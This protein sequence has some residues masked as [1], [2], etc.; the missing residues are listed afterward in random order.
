MPA[1]PHLLVWAGVLADL[2][3]PSCKSLLI[4]ALEL[5]PNRLSLTIHSCQ[6]TCCPDCEQPARRVHSHYTRT[7]T[8]VPWAGVAARIFFRARRF[9]CDNPACERRT[10]T[11]QLPE[12]LARYARRTHRLAAA[13]QTLAF[14]LG[15]EPGARAARHLEMPASPDTLLRLIRK[16]PEITCP[17]P[18]V[19]GVDDWAFRKG[20]T[21]GTILIDVESGG[22]VDLLP[23]RSQETFTR[24]LQAH[25]GIEIITRD[26]ASAYAL[27]AADGAPQALQVA[28]RFHLLVNLRKTVERFLDRHQADLRKVRRSP[29]APPPEV[30]AGN[31]ANSEPSALALAAEVR[32]A[33]EQRRLER[34]QAVRA[35]KQQGLSRAAIARQLGMSVNTARRYMQADEFPVRAPNR[36]ST[37]ERFSQFLR[38]RWQQGCHSP[39]RLWR[40]SQHAGFRGS[41]SSIRRW[42]ARAHFDRRLP[43][44]PET[45]RRESPPPDSPPLSS[46]QAAWVLLKAD[47]DLKDWEKEWR[48]QLQ[49]QCAAV[50]SAYELAQH[51]LKMV[52]K[53]IPAD[54]E[55]WINQATACGLID[56]RNFALN[57]KRDF[58]AVQAA[59]TLP[60]SNGP[61]EGHVHRLK[62]IKRQMYGRAKFDLLRKRVLRA[63]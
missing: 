39:T 24:W 27:A 41:L 48:T 38:D 6:E 3:F 59:L 28:D 57:L 14:A 22:P 40:D 25:P 61:T 37:A 19:L 15:G 7:V 8:D 32:Q 55:T 12:L 47:S 9:F 58:A 21:Y 16:A 63:G 20:Q 4:D 44:P 54:L 35:L 30:K 42:L 13:L 17:S 50:G 53:Q 60:W 2:L 52:R 11:E 1:Y 49:S 45:A 31:Q 29:V 43:I 46:Q 51:F 33:Q 18:R 36:I 5:Q 34:F 26:R 56:F 10:F 62:A 23:D